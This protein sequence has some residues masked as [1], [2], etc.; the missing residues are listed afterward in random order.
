MKSYCDLYFFLGY[1]VCL[2]AIEVIDLSLSRLIK[3]VQLI[4]NDFRAY[5]H[6]KVGFDWQSV[7]ASATAEFLLSFPRHL[8]D[9]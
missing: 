6:N 5:L 3:I 8:L 1:I 2:E 4:A 7:S 9:R